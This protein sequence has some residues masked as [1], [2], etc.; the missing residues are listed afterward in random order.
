MST[1]SQAQPEVSRDPED[2]R[3]TRHFEEQRKDRNIPMEMIDET[4]TDGDI[5]QSHQKPHCRVF[6]SNTLRVVFD[7]EVNEIITVTTPSGHRD[8]L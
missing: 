1:T 5:E 4:I 3:T 8:Y 2:Y 7:P 6:T